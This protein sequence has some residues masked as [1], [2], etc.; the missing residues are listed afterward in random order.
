LSFIKSYIGE[1]PSTLLS[2]LAFE[3]IWHLHPEEYHVIYM[4]VKKVVENID[5]RLNGLLLN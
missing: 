5:D 2:S 1:L 4:H 3:E